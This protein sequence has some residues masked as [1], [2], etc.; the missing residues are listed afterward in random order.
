MSS[1]ALSLAFHLG[2]IPHSAN[3]V[4]GHP[5]AVQPTLSQYRELSPRHTFLAG[6][7]GPAGW[8]T[9]QPMPVDLHQTLLRSL[10]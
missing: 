7:V 8:H 4:P 2:P 10:P 5:S 6:E 9:A 1:P 3:M